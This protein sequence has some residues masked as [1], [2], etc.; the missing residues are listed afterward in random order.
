MSVC[1]SSCSKQSGPAPN[2]LFSASSTFL[3][4]LS[5]DL[6]GLEGWRN[7]RLVLRRR[8]TGLWSQGPQAPSP[9]LSRGSCNKI[10]SVSPATAGLI[11]FCFN[12]FFLNKIVDQMY[13]LQ[14]LS[15]HETLILPRPADWIISKLDLKW[16]EIMISGEV[17]SVAMLM[18]CCWCR[19][20]KS[21]IVQL[22]L[23]R[24]YIVATSVWPTRWTQS[25][26]VWNTNLHKH[27]QKLHMLYV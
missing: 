17:S 16:V 22:R 8:E 15:W 10:S 7:L 19:C 11:I 12:I 4:K 1:F 21:S 3:Y 5:L 14:L 24:K 13:F 26:W 18:P 6:V 27:K 2:S 9:S 20:V 23:N 25:V